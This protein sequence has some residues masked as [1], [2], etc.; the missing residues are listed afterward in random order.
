MFSYFPGARSDHYRPW[1]LA[2]LVG[3]ILV[4]ASVACG[5]GLFRSG[6]RRSV[7]QKSF[8]WGLCGRAEKREKK[9]ISRSAAARFL[10]TESKPKAPSSGG[11]HRKSIRTYMQSKSHIGGGS[12]ARLTL[13]HLF[14][15]CI[16]EVVDVI[17][18][19]TRP[20]H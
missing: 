9:P 1:Q 16:T 5:A 7:A 20:V 8:L 13:Y 2:N 12:F 19:S 6:E 17:Y 18:I 10:A 15:C 3:E 4:V 11:A 14:K